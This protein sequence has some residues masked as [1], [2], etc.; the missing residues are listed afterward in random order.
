MQ[1]HE[2]I[3]SREAIHAYF[4]QLLDLSGKQAQ[5]M[6]HILALIQSGTFPFRTLADRF[7][8]I[9]NPTR[10]IYIPLGE[11][12]EL[13]DRFRSGQRSRNLFRKLGQYGVSVYAGHFAALEQAGDLE[14]LEDG[15]AILWNTALYSGET[16]LSLAADNGKG[17][18]I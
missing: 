9:D 3:A 7:H 1:R 17:L 12:E 5:D 6:Q 2:D 8:L 10:T 18:F 16:G 4:S 14:L 11:G 13:A 15:T